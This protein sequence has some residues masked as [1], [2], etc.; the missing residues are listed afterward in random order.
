MIT[1]ITGVPGMGKT[2]LMVSMLIEEEKK[3]DR[4]LYVMGVDNLLIEHQ[5]LPTIDLWTYS[6]S[7]KD[8]PSLELFY[9]TFPPNSILIIDEAQKIYRPRSS[10][11]KVP[12]IV[13]ALETHRHTGIDIWLLTQKPSLLDSNVRDLCG[14]HMHIRNSILGRKIYEWPEYN[15]ITETNLKSAASRFFR[16]PKSAFALYKSSELH[17]KQPRRIHNAFIVLALMIPLLFYQFYSLYTKFDSKINQTDKPLIGSLD[18]ITSENKLGFFDVNL[19]S[20]NK[21]LKIDDSDKLQ[22]LPQNQEIKHPFSGFDFVIKG[23]IKS[24]RLTL[25]YY[26][27]TNGLKSLFLTDQDL[28]K[29]GYSITQLND[30]SSF[31]FFQGAQI[32]VT[33]EADQMTTERSE[34]RHFNREA[35]P[36]KSGVSG[37]LSP[38]GGSFHIPPNTKGLRSRTS[39]NN[40]SPS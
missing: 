1:I 18:R 11:S 26:R 36:L 16:P 20:Q 9:F 28:I 5:K 33:C 19:P 2:A 15:A 6:K 32:T 40:P 12:P 23:I 24:K 14:R 25:T 7:D 31:L 13:S 8:D 27:I 17:T 21:H 3:G 37:D 10:S 35:S 29:L 4:P 38:D 34:N 30:C 22:P 39:S